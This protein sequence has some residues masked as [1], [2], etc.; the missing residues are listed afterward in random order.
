M[1]EEASGIDLVRALAAITPTAHTPVALLTSYAPGHSSLA[2]LPANAAIIRKGT[3][4]G[5]DLANA[6]A[7]F[8]IT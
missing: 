8:K 6:L 1:L 5:E 4:F 7:R 2:D 3:A